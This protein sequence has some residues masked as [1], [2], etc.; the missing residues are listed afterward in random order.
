MQQVRSSS[1]R[2]R[3]PFRAVGEHKG[4]LARLHSSHSISPLA[5]AFTGA[6]MRRSDFFSGMASLSLPP[7]TLPLS[8]EKISL[9]KDEWL[10]AAP[11]RSRDIGRRVD[12]FAQTR[13]PY[14]ASLSLGAAIPHALT[15]KVGSGSLPASCSCLRF[16]VASS[17]LHTGLTRRHSSMPGAP[18]RPTGSSDPAEVSLSTTHALIL[19]HPLH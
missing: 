6:T 14:K 18:S 4:Q 9:G 3:A 13:R 5:P 16:M 2:F 8:P 17:W 12:E 10:P 7:S 19:L 15:G 1:S 11:V